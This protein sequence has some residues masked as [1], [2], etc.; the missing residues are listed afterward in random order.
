VLVPKKKIKVKKRHM[1]LLEV[2][3]ALA[4]IALCVLPLLA[5]HAFLLKQQ[6]QFI[7]TI[8]LDHMVNLLYADTVE[9]LHRQEIA[10]QSIQEKTVFPVDASTYARIHYDKTLPFTGSYRFE[11]S[12]HKIND[13]ENWGV[14]LLK[15]VFTFVPTQI[16]AEGETEKKLK[17]FEYTYQV[18]VTY[19][20]GEQRVEETPAEG[21][22]QPNG[23]QSRTPRT[24]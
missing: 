14:H 3:I 17:T 12:K 24:G 10:W 2:M 8:E 20:A 18:F 21:Q 6:K 22:G 15:L 4:L 13:K 5:P 19:N 9:R 1:I 16:I 23:K 11:D 7:S